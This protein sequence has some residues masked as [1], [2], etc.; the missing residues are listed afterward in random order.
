MGGT[1]GPG[2]VPLCWRCFAKHPLSSS[3]EMALRFQPVV[4]SPLYSPFR[5]L[6]LS[7]VCFRCC[8]HCTRN[9]RVI[10]WQQFPRRSR[11][12]FSRRSDSSPELGTQ[13]R[14]TARCFPCGALSTGRRAPPAAPTCSGWGQ[15]CGS[16]PAF[17]PSLTPLQGEET[18]AFF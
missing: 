17:R 10:L 1:N 13:D 11:C 8:E 18:A 16:Q 12:K 6:H 15:A 7:V 2:L 5:R 14:E 3:A 4:L 9:T